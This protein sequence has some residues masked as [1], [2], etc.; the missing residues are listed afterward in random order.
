M[1]EFYIF[2]G[3]IVQCIPISMMHITESLQLEPCK[4]PLH[5]AAAQSLIASSLKKRA[6]LGMRQLGV[7]RVES[8]TLRAANINHI[9]ESFFI[10]PISRQ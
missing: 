10:N 5:I 6:S 2:D 9:S 3:A 7:R 8:T 4:Q 1:Q